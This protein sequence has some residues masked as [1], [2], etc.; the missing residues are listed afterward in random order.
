MSALRRLV[1]RMRNGVDVI[2]GT[3]EAEA[4]VPGFFESEGE[5]FHIIHADKRRV[6]Y[7]QQEPLPFPDSWKQFLPEGTPLAGK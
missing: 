7:E 2:Q 5:R 4:E 3:I 1:I 6:H